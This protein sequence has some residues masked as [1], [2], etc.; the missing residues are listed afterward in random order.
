M[1]KNAKKDNNQIDFTILTRF[2]VFINELS[3]HQ[4]ILS[5]KLLKII[6][7]RSILLY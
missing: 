4:L 7:I 2:T 1:A 5:L 6:I 3:I